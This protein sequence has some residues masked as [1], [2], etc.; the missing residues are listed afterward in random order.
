MNA[1]VAVAEWNEIKVI[2]YKNKLNE[3]FIQLLSGN[4]IAN[5]WVVEECCVSRAIGILLIGI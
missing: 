4:F 2:K 1:D 5:L 3:T